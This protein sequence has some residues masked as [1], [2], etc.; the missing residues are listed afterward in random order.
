M[1]S[2]DIIGRAERGVYRT[3][4]A[5]V[6]ELHQIVEAHRLLESGTA[7]GKIVVRAPS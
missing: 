5:H 4:P 2:D 3:A 7:R 1:P 6:F